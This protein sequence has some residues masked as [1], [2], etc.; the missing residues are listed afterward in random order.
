MATALFQRG[1][2]ALMN[3]T[4]ITSGLVF[5]NTDQHKIYLDDA[6]TRTMYGGYTDVINNLSSA[7]AQNTFSA[8]FVTN[9]FLQKTSVVNTKANAM[10]VT[11]NNIPLGC[12]AFKEAVGTSDISNLGSN[13]TEAIS[14]L[15]SRSLVKLWDN[16]N[17]QTPTG[18]DWDGTFTITIPNLYKFDRIIIESI[19]DYHLQYVYGF[20]FNISYEL[21]SDIEVVETNIDISYSP[22]ST[23]RGNVEHMEFNK[24]STSDGFLYYSRPIIIERNQNTI[25]FGNTIKSIHKGDNTWQRVEYTSDSSANLGSSTYLLPYRIYGMSGTA[26]AGDIS[27]TDITDAQ[28]N[29]IERLI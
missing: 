19:Y 2:N 14:V 22:A 25:T 13:L 5:F 18:G 23:I 17:V 8:N 26:S 10:N 29:Q 7:T 20:D 3:N 4:P 6:N 24:L 1:N 12:L 21:P 16:A 9:N 28:W 11:Q 15:G 27:P